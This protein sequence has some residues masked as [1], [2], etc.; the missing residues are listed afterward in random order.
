MT[1]NRSACVAGVALITLVGAVGQNQYSGMS[2]EA[3]AN[4]KMGLQM[5]A[6]GDHVHASWRFGMAIQQSAPSAALFFPRGVSY[7]ALHNYAATQ[8]GFQTSLHVRPNFPTPHPPLQT[9]RQ[10]LGTL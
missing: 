4:F 1:R 2:S 9:T 10:P 5:Q 7:L 6:R 8:T 3:A